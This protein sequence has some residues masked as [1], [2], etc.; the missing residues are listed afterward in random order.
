MNGVS[1][2]SGISEYLIKLSVWFPSTSDECDKLCY[3]IVEYVQLHASVM[4][5]T[6]E[7]VA[8]YGWLWNKE[9]WWISRLLPMRTR[10]K[11]EIVPSIDS[12]YKSVPGFIRIQE[13]FFSF[14]G[15]TGKVFKQ[16]GWSTRKIRPW[17]IFAVLFKDR[18][19]R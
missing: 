14:L 17:S 15:P 9:S 12:F 11:A 19:N 16:I 18:E 1:G 4:R 7:Q 5:H 3:P 8:V 10:D 6:R 2:V 13:W